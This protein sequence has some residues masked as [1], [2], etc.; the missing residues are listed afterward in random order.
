LIKQLGEIDQLLQRLAQQAT[1]YD[2]QNKTPSFGKQPSGNQAL[3]NRPLAYKPLINKPRFNKSLFKSKSPNLADY[4]NESFCLLNDVRELVTTNS[5]TS[6][7][8]YQC[9]K[10]VDQ[11]QAIRKALTNQQQRENSSQIY[12]TNRKPVTK[13]VMPSR[14]ELYQELSKHHDYQ[15]KFE[16]KIHQQ[17]Q[18]LASAP[19]DEQPMRQ[20]EI[21]KLHQRLGQ[22]RK[23]IICIEKNIQRL[24]S[25]NLS[26]RNR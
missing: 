2:Q 15:Q 7:L 21:L 20:Q 26:P 13:S 6:L 1:N 14:V 23:A 16:G 8:Q 12:S 25:S 3:T 19:I 18:Q 9:N 24:E 17:E 11:C 5:D 22:C 10:L 4:V